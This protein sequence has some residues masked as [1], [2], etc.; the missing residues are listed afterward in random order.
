MSGQVHTQ[1][2]I[3]FFFLFK[4]KTITI[5]HFSHSNFGQR[6]EPSTA[7]PS[8]SLCASWLGFD[9]HLRR[10]LLLLFSFYNTLFFFSH[11]G[12]SFTSPPPPALKPENENPTSHLSFRRQRRT[13]LRPKNAVTKESPSLSP[14]L[15]SVN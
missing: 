8:F 5:Y 11:L 6:R 9:S 15:P 3:F 14:T 1:H 4:Y 7:A 13:S 2:L 10:L 12:H